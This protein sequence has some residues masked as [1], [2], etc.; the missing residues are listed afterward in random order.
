M[1][2]DRRGCSIPPRAG[3]QPATGGAA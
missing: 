2:L 1:G 3:G